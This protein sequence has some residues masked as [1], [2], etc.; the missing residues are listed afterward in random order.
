VV[1]LLS[2]ENRSQRRVARRAVFG[3]CVA[4]EW[5]CK[6]IGTAL[7]EA[8]IDWAETNLL[9]EKIDLAVFANNGKGRPTLSEAGLRGGRTAATGS[10]V[11]ARAV[12]G[13]YSDV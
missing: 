4:D 13:R 7:P 9:I 11:R 3:F 12:R 6:I 10:E 5:K 2:F 8:L 1:G